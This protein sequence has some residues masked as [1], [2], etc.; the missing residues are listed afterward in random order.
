MT[1]PPLFVSLTISPSGLIVNTTKGVTVTVTEEG[2][3]LLTARL[4]LR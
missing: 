2:A 4:A 1:G 3:E